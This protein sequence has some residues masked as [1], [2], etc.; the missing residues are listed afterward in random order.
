MY[1]PRLRDIPEEIRSKLSIVVDID[2][3]QWQGS[4]RCSGYKQTG[5][6]IEIL[7]P[8]VM[9][10]EPENNEDRFGFRV[11]AWYK[12]IR[13]PHTHVR[14]KPYDDRYELEREIRLDAKLHTEQH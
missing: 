11:Y 14:M 4:M 6:A 13:T 12:L 3:P 9:F 1:F 8:V 2:Q 7:G 10:A 5:D